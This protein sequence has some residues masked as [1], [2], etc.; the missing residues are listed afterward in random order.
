M[1]VVYRFDMAKD[2]CKDTLFCIAIFK[3]VKSH[4]NLKLQRKAFAHQYGHHIILQF[5]FS[6]IGY[7]IYLLDMNVVF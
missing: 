5:L 7:S 6:K 4:I 3:K 2:T 1:T